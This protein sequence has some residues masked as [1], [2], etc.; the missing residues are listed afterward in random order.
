[1]CILHA[2]CHMAEKMVQQLL[3]AGMRKHPSGQQLDKFVANVE[4]CMNETILCR[5]TASVSKGWMFLLKD[6]KLDDVNLSNKRAHTVTKNLTNLVEV[7]TAK[8]D[9]EYWNKWTTVC[10]QF[11]TVTEWLDLKI[12]FKFEEVCNFQKDAD[13]F[14]STYF[15][16]T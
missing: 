11:L 15:D 13:L 10:S 5:V 3:I 7:C 6:R 12:I 4:T 9:V 1:M 8:Y 2:H 14:C 16:I